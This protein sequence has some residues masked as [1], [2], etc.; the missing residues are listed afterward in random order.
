MFK[1]TL[2]YRSLFIFIFI[3]AF[4]S[5]D[6]RKSVHEALNNDIET[7]KQQA[8]M[9]DYFPKTDVQFYSDTLLDSGYRIALKTIPDFNNSVV[10]ESQKNDIEVQTNFRN[11]MFQL[12]LY[13]EDDLLT[14]ELFNKNRLEALMTKYSE[15]TDLKGHVLKAVNVSLDK[16]T[17]NAFVIELIY[18]TPDSG[19]ETP[20]DIIMNPTGSF[21]LRTS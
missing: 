10:V 5:C 3:T 9:K 1:P 2:L 14:T 17:P 16:T 13:R 15:G 4:W 18:Y 8:S 12:D 20:I 7:F 11:Y 6:G 21:Y 19:I